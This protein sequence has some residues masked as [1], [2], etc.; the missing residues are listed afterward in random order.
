VA[1]APAGQSAQGAWGTHAAEQSKMTIPPLLTLSVV[2]HGNAGEVRRLL[3][4]MERHES[5]MQRFQLVITDNLKDDLPGFDASPWASLHL[6]RNA[7]P[8]GFAENHNRAFEFAAGEYFAI[9][10]P[11]LIFER[12]VFDGLITSLHAHEADL[13]APQIVDASGSPQDS[14]RSLP[15]PFELVRRRLPGYR[16]Q[17]PPPA[18]DGLIRPDWIAAM[19]WLMPSNLYRSLGGMDGRYKLYL[20]DVD[21]CTRARLAGYTIVVDPRLSVRHDAA[22]SSRRRA[23]YLFLHMQ[24]AFRFF[25][26]RVYRQARRR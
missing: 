10:N 20:E 12:P 26:S 19:F 15:T 4:S 7:R 17:P 22:R 21:F 23:Y 2:S 25:T 13:I 9:L 8:K 14:F 24:S 18:S 11:D 1:G 5:A 3:A 16:F 6:L